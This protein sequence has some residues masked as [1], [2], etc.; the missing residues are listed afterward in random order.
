MVLHDG[1]IKIVDFG[2][3][4]LGDNTMTRTGQIVGSLYYMAPEQ[5]REKGIDARTDIYATGVVLYQLLTHAL[6]FEGESA[7]STLA[8]IVTEEAPRFSQFGVTCPPE[9]ETATLKALAKNP[10][11]RYPTAEA[12]ALAL[13]E[14]QA[15]L[16]QESIREYLQ[17][18]DLLYQSQE[19]LQAQE[20]VQKALK[21]DRQNTTA[22]RMLSAIRSE[23]QAQLSAEQ[24]RQ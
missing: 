14:I 2:I 12:F 18:A 15:Q 8:K 21:L 7:G 4:R 1:N 5:I 20:F 24:V 3:A 16:K 22:A 9:L 23:V 11:E 13:T 19:L 6:P 10:S 17:R